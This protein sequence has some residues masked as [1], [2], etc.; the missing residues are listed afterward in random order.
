MTAW[1]FWS[2]FVAES[3]LFGMEPAADCIITREGKNCDFEVKWAN[4]KVKMG[5]DKGSKKTKK[6]NPVH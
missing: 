1:K 6:I 2:Y 3:V 5:S 4:A